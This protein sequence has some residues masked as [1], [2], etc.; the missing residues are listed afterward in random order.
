[1]SSWLVSVNVYE[2]P[3]YS[4][5]VTCDHVPVFEQVSASTVVVVLIVLSFRVAVA[6]S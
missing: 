6:Q 3:G 5:F 2:S 1:M 4:D